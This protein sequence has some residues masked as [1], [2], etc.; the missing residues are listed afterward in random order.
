M[1][2]A[3]ETVLRPSEYTIFRNCIPAPGRFC[4]V[5]YTFSRENIERAPVYAWSDDKKFAVQIVPS[6]LYVMAVILKTGNTFTF[7]TRLHCDFGEHELRAQE[8]VANNFSD[9]LDDIYDFADSDVAVPP[10]APLKPV[11]HFYMEDIGD[12]MDY[13]KMTAKLI[14]L[15]GGE[16]IFISRDFESRVEPEDESLPRISARIKPFPRIEVNRYVDGVAIK[17]GK[18]E[19]F[20]VMFSEPVILVAGP[21]MPVF[22]A[23]KTVNVDIKSEYMEKNYRV[24]GV[25]TVDV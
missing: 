22:L 2:F 25:F 15:N 19:E 3:I 5:F 9:I 17:R 24:T 20:K 21:A 4:S 18:A 13:V 14:G 1:S 11:M 7:K 23:K 8:I 10:R 12:V 6:K 16:A